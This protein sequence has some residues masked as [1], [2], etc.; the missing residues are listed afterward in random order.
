MIAATAGDV[1]RSAHMWHACITMF[2]N[3]EYLDAGLQSDSACLHCPLLWSLSFALHFQLLYTSSCIVVRPCLWSG[4]CVL[5]LSRCT[6]GLRT[7]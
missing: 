4:R 1:C 7:S 2:L 3:S 5:K 6:Q